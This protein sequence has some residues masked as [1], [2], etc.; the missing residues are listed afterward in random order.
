M[1]IPVKVVSRWD[2]FNQR[3]GYHLAL[4]VRA[5]AVDTGARLLDG[6][7]LGWRAAEAVEAVSEVNEGRGVVGLAP[8]RVVG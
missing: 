8:F 2:R 6:V 1:G 4:G 5:S 7:F 3:F